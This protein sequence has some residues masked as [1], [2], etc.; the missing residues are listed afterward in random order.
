MLQHGVGWGAP[1]YRSGVKSAG[2]RA[3]APEP[4]NSAMPHNQVL[5]AR[6]EVL[7]MRKQVL[8]VRKQELPM[9]QNT[10]VENYSI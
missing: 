3:V 10:C 2:A 9:L 8:P 1:R 5:P 7:P 4:F 6:K